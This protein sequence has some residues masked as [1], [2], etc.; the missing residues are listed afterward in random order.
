M[1]K[2]RHNHLLSPERHQKRQIFLEKRAGKRR[3]PAT[4][5][6]NKPTPPMVI[7]G[8]MGKG[9]CSRVRQKAWQRL[10]YIILHN[11]RWQT[12]SLLTSL[13]PPLPCFSWSSP[14]I[15]RPQQQRPWNGR[16]WSPWGDTHHSEGPGPSQSGSGA[17]ETGYLLHQGTEL[18]GLRSCW[19]YGGVETQLP[20]LLTNYLRFFT[21]SVPPVSKLQHRLH[22]IPLIPSPPGTP[23]V[24][25][26]A[27][28]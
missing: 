2:D 4:A 25:E 21:L 7:G 28:T 24:P 1:W 10:S 22:L 20:A 15:T 13:T 12:F 5:A 14:D 3:R 18:D 9:S 11:C 17:E 26:P 19:W 16:G 27:Q 23:D 8:R 6:A